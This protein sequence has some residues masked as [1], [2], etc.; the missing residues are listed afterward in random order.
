M[1]T[2]L[3]YDL[4]SLPKGANFEEIME[5]YMDQKIIIYDSGR[6]GKPQIIPAGEEIKFEFKDTKKK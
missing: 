5:A 3:I 2:T 1:E 4:A 6:G